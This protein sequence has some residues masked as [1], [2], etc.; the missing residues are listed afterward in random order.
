MKSETGLLS[1]HRQQMWPI[2]HTVLSLFH[3]ILYISVTELVVWLLFGGPE[4][5]KGLRD[6][7][8]NI[9]NLMATGQIC[10]SM[11]VT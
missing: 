1:Y 9:T 11:K 3:L 7:N 5:A 4:A 8:V 10:A 2:N 6:K